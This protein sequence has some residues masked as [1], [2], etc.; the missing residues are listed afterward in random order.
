MVVD[1]KSK[2]I[3]LANKE[4][5]IIANYDKDQKLT[6][7][8]QLCNFLK[9]K[10]VS[11]DEA[12]EGSGIRIRSEVAIK[13][14]SEKGKAQDKNK[15]HSQNLWDYIFGSND[16]KASSKKETIFKSKNPKRYIQVKTSMISEGT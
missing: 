5:E 7:K 12:K 1:L 14:R 3:V 2:D 16:F 15:K 11:N 13:P 10:V 8:Q 9:H 4:M 6:F